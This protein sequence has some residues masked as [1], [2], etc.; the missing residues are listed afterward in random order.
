MAAAVV[1]GGDCLCLLVV[2]FVRLYCA[3]RIIVNSKGIFL[4]EK[5]IQVN[6]GVTLTTRLFGPLRTGQASMS[7]MLRVCKNKEESHTF[8]QRSLC[9]G[10][11]RTLFH[12]DYITTCTSTETHNTRG[13]G[14]IKSPS[15]LLCDK[16]WWGLLLNSRSW[17][18]SGAFGKIIAS[19]TLL[20]RGQQFPFLSPFSSISCMLLLLT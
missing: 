10:R 1:R 12:V 14:P 9:V 17:N 2:G 11:W 16:R 3:C 20:Q 7:M 19:R 18:L 15:S 8:Y 4:Q 5:G 13:V 6:K